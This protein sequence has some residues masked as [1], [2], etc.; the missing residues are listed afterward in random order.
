MKT[1]YSFEEETTVASP[2]LVFYKKIIE[3]NIDRMI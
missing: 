1:L 3:D 2:Q